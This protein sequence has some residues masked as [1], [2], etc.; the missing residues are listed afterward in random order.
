MDRRQ[1]EIILA[2]VKYL[3][4]SEAAWETSFSASTISKQVSAAEEELGVRIFERKGRSKVSLT[5]AGES[6]LPYLQRIADDYAA[7]N[8]QITAIINERSNQLSIACPTGFSTLGEDELIAQFCY[9]HPEVTINQVFGSGDVCQLMMEQGHVDAAFRLVLPKDLAHPLGSTRKTVPQGGDLL[10]F[11]LYENHLLIA[12]K[13]GHPAI[14]DGRVDLADLHGETFL[15]RQFTCGEHKDEKITCFE[16][17]CASEGFTP[18]IQYL[19]N[20]RNSAA[21]NLVAEGVGVAPLMYTPGITYPGVAFVP[22]TRQYYKTITA[23]YCLKSNRSIGLKKF[24][25]CVKNSKKLLNIS[26]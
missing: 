17:A 14:K 3:S 22:V 23:I 19:P 4:F 24:I 10:V 6:I 11:P 9:T 20:L 1:V 12:M 15:F 7:L 13:S 5:P 2:V 26:F 18:N 25:N 21:F 16:Q 8:T